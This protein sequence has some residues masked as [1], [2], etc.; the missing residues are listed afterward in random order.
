M[1]NQHIGS[2]R[3]LAGKDLV[4][5]MGAM[6]AQDAAMFKWAVGVR[7]PGSTEKGI[8]AAFNRGDILRTHLLRP[9]WHLVSRD[10]IHWLLEL[11]APS[12]L[13]SQKSR[14][15]E[16][17][18]TGSILSLSN[19]VIEKALIN[20]VHLQRQELVARLNQ[21]G[22][23]T[24]ENRA[25]HI[26]SVAELQGLICSGRLIDGK[27]TYALLADRAPK[28]EQLSKDEALSRLALRYFCS[29]GPATIKDFSWWAGLIQRDANLAVES[30]K[31]ELS[32]ET[33]EGQTYWF[34]NNPTTAQGRDE[35]VWLLPPFDEY[36]ISYQERSAM[37]PGGIAT[38]AISQNGM[39][40]G[41]VVV[42]GGVIGTWKRTIKKDRVEIQIE[43]FQQPSN[44]IVN[45]IEQAAV[46]YGQFLGKEAHVIFDRVDQQR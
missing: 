27:H 18:L 12:I 17:G 15:A 41:V 23:D 24:K 30:I 46:H 36:I 9:T 14:L 32:S 8:E 31:Y 21:A 26:F 22:I 13:G 3:I 34:S 19:A 6:Q 39:F 16:L 28:T 4:A 33:V 42:D 10:D 38:K 11:T 25:S 35:K 37:L 29:H 7:L 2:H 43:L 5:W 40:R 1:S 44:T 45:Q 20:G